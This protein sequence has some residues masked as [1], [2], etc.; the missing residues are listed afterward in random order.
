M[1]N[2][3]TNIAYD[4]VFI[5]FPELFAGVICS[6]Y[7]KQLLTAAA[8]P[9]FYLGRHPLEQEVLQDAV[10]GLPLLPAQAIEQPVFLPPDLRG[11]RPHLSGIPAGLPVPAVSASGTFVPLPRF[12]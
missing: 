10:R 2:I 9:G 1:N 12:L 4:A 3:D 5:H 8:E 7:V 11:S 6:W